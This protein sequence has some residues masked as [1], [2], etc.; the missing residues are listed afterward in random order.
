MVQG[1]GSAVYKARTEPDS[2]TILGAGTTTQEDRGQREPT[3]GL[4]S[5]HGTANVEPK[6]G[7]RCEASGRQYGTIDS[8][9]S[10]NAVIPNGWG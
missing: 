6:G 4:K 1:N 8:S 5:Q 9:N 3:D 2:K 10:W 7:S